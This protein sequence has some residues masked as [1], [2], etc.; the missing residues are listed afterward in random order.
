[1]LCCLLSGCRRP[2]FYGMGNQLLVHFHGV[3]YDSIA[4]LDI[5]F[6]NRLLRVRVSCLRVEADLN[7]FSGRCFDGN[8]RVRNLS[9][10]AG[11]VFFAA[12]SGGDCG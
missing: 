7:G 2:N 10:R 8:G 3:D 11:H 5:G 12:V 6:L 4:D 9:H 1:M